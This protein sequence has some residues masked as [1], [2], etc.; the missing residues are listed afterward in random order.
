M[1][2]NDPGATS[3]FCVIFYRSSSEGKTYV[4]VAPTTIEIMVLLCLWVVLGADSDCS[5]IFREYGI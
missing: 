5:V 1:A 3:K 4:A 2:H